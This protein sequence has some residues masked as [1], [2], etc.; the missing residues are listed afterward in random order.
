MKKICKIIK[1][2]E[3]LFNIF[4]L[5]LG[6]TA[7]KQIQITFKGEPNKG[8]QN[9]KV[10]NYTINGMANGRDIWNSTSNMYGQF[11]IWYSKSFRKWA[12]G[13]E[14]EKNADIDQDSFFVNNQVLA[15]I[16]SEENFLECPYDLKSE[17]WSYYS[18][19]GMTSAKENE[20]NIVCSKLG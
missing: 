17:K 18:D 14:N 13:S 6:C 11:Y 4:S 16:V 5:Y 9:K 3:R 15:G 12:I 8:H 20:I 19:L 1:H 10:G 7:C 2:V